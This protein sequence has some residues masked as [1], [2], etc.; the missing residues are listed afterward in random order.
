M[1]ESANREIVDEPAALA[2]LAE[3]A[4]RED[5]A[6]RGERVVLLRMLGRLEE[7]ARQGRAAYEAARLEG[8][9]RQQVA[10]L[11]RLAHVLQYQRDWAAADQAFDE[12]MEQAQAVGEP[13][14]I[15]FA[16]QHAGRNH[17]DQGRYAEALAAF[18]AALALREAHGA[19]ADQLESTLGALRA[20]EQRLANDREGTTRPDGTTR[21]NGTTRPSGIAGPEDAA[22][23]AGA[24]HPMVP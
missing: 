1:D 13:L 20:T 11:I 23:Q 10:A 8:T 14:L 24:A 5:L 17:V 21:P 6:A 9:P 2:R 16:H 19:P 7:A 12:A 22:G 15:A 18:R 4:G 3:L